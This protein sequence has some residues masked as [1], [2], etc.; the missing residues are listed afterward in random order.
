MY[1][2]K[3]SESFPSKLQRKAAKDGDIIV[4]GATGRCLSDRE[5]LYSRAN[6]EK[7]KRYGFTESDN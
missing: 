2:R 4:A 3:S 6:T 7:T 1:M 5:L